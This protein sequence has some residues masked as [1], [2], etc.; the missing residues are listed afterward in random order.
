VRERS[1]IRSSPA[2]LPGLSVAYAGNTATYSTTSELKRET[3][4]P[5]GR[6]NN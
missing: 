6:L 5:Y 4:R 3:V 1:L 2:C